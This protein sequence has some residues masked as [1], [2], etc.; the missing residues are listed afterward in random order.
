MNSGGVDVEA[1]FDRYVTETMVCEQITAPGVLISLPGPAST[2]LPEVLTTILTDPRV[3]YVADN[4]GRRTKAE[5][6][7]AFAVWLDLHGRPHLPHR[8][9]S[10]AARLIFAVYSLP[11]RWPPTAPQ[12]YPDDIVLPGAST[13][14]SVQRLLAETKVAAAQQEWK[15]YLDA[16]EDDPWL[17]PR[18][19]RTRDNLEPELWWLHNT[20]PPT[21][22]TPPWPASP[23]PLILRG[24]DDHY[25]VAD[26]TA[27]RWLERGSPWNAARALA[28]RHPRLLAGAFT[29]A[30]LAAAAV[31]A[32][33]LAGSGHIARCLAAGEIIA[34]LLGAA[35]LPP[36]FQALLMLRIPAAAAVGVGLLLTLTTSWWVTHTAWWAGAGMLAT[37]TAYLILDARRHGASRLAM[38]Y[39]GAGIALIGALYAFVLSTAALGWVVPRLGDHGDCLTGWWNHNPYQP[40]PLDTKAPTIDG[41]DDKPDSCAKALRAPTAAAPAATLLLMTGWS[42]GFGLGAQILWDDR[43]VTAPLARQRRTRGT[44]P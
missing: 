26:D 36:R 42:L 43:P 18:Y 28:P 33:V 1:V 29:V 24:G 12:P 38:L 16:A 37:A 10:R 35:A 44:P 25:R 7:L 21:S 32:A 8:W 17:A 5:T 27:E 14:T 41:V 4:R 40:L 30:I 22:G 11:H 39:R 19:A 6:L 23:A 20:W 34:G 15:S 13:A 31:V 2:P 3:L 9:Q